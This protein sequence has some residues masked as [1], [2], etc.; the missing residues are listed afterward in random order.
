MTTR[1]HFWQLSGT[2]LLLLT[3]LNEILIVLPGYLFDFTGSCIKLTPFST[4][5]ALMAFAF[6]LV[7]PTL[8][9][10]LFVTGLIRVAVSISSRNDIFSS[11]LIMSTNGLLIV[12]IILDNCGSV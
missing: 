12:V 9:F 10:A 8:S 2:T 1:K 7:Y 5:F 11:L 6:G 3:L 4:L